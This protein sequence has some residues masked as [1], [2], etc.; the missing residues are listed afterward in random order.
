MRA[1]LDELQTV[2]NDVI[3][4]LRLAIFALRPVS[5]D[6]W[7]LPGANPAGRRLW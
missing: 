7:F 2:L 6:G 1:T 5:I 3:V 4:D